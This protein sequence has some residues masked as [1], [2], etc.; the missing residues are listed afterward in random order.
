MPTDTLSNQPDA[1]VAKFAAIKVDIKA[2]LEQH[3][4]RPALPHEAA[5]A[6]TDV[7]L[8]VPVL[9]QKLLALEIRLDKAGL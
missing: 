5:N 9:L 2:A 6:M 3:L 7:G 8:M 1:S 4:G